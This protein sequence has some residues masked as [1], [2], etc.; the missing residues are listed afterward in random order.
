MLV[1]KA[2]SNFT[3]SMRAEGLSTETIRWYCQR[4]RRLTKFLGGDD[5]PVESITPQRLRAFVAGLRE[6]VKL[7]ADHP[8]RPSEEGYLSDETIRTYVRALR[9]FFNFLEEE[10]AI[11]KSPARAVKMPKEK[12][13]PKAIVEEDALLILEEAQR[14]SPR[15]YTLVIFLLDTGCRVG[16]VAGLD[17]EDVDLSE[18]LAYVRHSKT[19]EPRFVPFNPDTAKALSEYLAGREDP[20]PCLFSG[21]RGRLLES[22]IY[23]LLERLADRAGVEGRFNPHS[24]RHRSAID[25]ILDGGDMA[26]LSQRL[27]HSSTRVTSDYYLRFQ[28]EELREIHDRHSSAKKFLRKLEEK[29]DDEG[30]GESEGEGGRG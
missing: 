2:V 28:V 1:K 19:G 18:R 7:Y 21:K 23:Q 8:Y 29:E 22:G 5:V 3:L 12:K 20:S 15:D 13:D 14:S 30:E 17:R 4:L 9:R 26:S 6:P 16:E 24:F 27:G 11:P 25:H 10:G